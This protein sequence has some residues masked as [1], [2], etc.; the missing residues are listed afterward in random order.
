MG[1]P[2]GSVISPLLFNILL[3]NLPDSVSNKAQIVQYADD[4]AM[5]MNVSLKRK[6]SLFEIK[7]I[8]KLYQQDL[9]AIS[10][11]IKCSGLE[12]SQ[13][14]TSM[15][16]FNNG[17]NPRHLPTLV[18]D[19]QVLQ[20]STEIKFLGVY[21]TPKLNWKKHFDYILHKAT[22]SLNLLKVVSK[23]HWGQDTKM[24]IHLALSLVRSKLSYG[25]EAFFSAPR[26]YLQ[27]LLSL[28][29]KAIKL[30][31]GVPVHTKTI[32]AYNMAGIVCLDQWRKLSCANYLVRSL[33][34]DNHTREELF[35]RSDVHFPRRSRKIAS[36]QTVAT[37]THDLFHDSSINPADVSKKHTSL[38][39]TNSRI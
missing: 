15:M 28:D 38:E 24:L 20:Y 19:G 10:N 35:L 14:K 11:F 33:A 16:L 3:H 18:V 17:Q 30:A 4:I 39:K 2:Q 6:T 1:I 25:Q 34:I 5:W 27:K 32:E 26:S 7:H 8:T 12:L 23:Q 13:D 22:K 36:L 21:L 31:L 29:S 37:Y 9:D